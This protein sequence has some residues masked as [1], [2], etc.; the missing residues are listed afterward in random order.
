[1]I[2]SHVKIH[3]TWY[4]SLRDPILFSTRE[5]TNS[6]IRN[7]KLFCGFFPDCVVITSYILRAGYGK[8]KYR[9]CLH[10]SIEVP[11]SSDC[12]GWNY[13]FSTPLFWKMHVRIMNIESKTGTIFRIFLNFTDFQ[14]PW[15]SG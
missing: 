14:T 10:A 12:F 9:P 4:I 3:A 13:L 7:F 5:L 6:D 15:G 1:M 11:P 2:N 8:H